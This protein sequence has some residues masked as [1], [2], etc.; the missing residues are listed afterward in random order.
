MISHNICVYLLHDVSEA[1]AVVWNE[2]TYGNINKIEW[3]SQN[4]ITLF[5]TV[6]S[7]GKQTRSVRNNR[8][9]KFT[10]LIGAYKSTIVHP[11]TAAR[12][13][14]P[15]ISVSNLSVSFIYK[16]F[17]FD[18]FESLESIEFPSQWQT[19]AM[20]MELARFALDNLYTYGRFHW[21]CCGFENNSLSSANFFCMCAPC[22]LQMK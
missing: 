17:T 11:V 5:W 12:T 9:L 10:I 21:I 3:L 14:M 7:D 18:N 2:Q 19:N 16:H 20:Q 8:R 4:H 13:I 22:W 1:S 6:R 15:T